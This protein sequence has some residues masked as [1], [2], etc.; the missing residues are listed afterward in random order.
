MEVTTAF[1]HSHRFFV[2]GAREVGAHSARKDPISNSASAI[3][4]DMDQRDLRA[5]LSRSDSA[6]FARPFPSRYPALWPDAI[7]CYSSST[8]SMSSHVRLPPRSILLRGDREPT[9]RL[10]DRLDDMSILPCAASQ[11]LQ[12]VGIR[13]LRV[14]LERP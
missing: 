2:F 3:S 1:E 11:R 9:T 14:V 7:N 12:F 4:L 8:Q 10:P 5:F 6:R 13:P